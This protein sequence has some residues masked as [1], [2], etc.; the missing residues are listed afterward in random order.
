MVEHKDWRRCQL[1]V[2]VRL[3]EQDYKVLGCMVEHK[4]WRRCQQL[5]VKV[6]LKEQDYKV[7]ECM[8]EH[9][10]WR[11]CQLVVKVRLKEQ[12]Y[13][14]LECMVEHKDW[15]LCQL[16]LGDIFTRKVHNLVRTVFGVRILWPSGS[17]FRKWTQIQV[18]SK[19][20]KRTLNCLK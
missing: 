8:V 20:L 9:K 3:K 15:R 13:K 7:L 12:D 2:K 19:T 5:V 11:R 17:V 10:D 1:V 16:G 6:R 14:V 18:L 4:D